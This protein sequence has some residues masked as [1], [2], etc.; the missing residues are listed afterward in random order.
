MQSLPV[1]VEDQQET[2]EQRRKRLAIEFRMVAEQY[3]AKLTELLNEGV[4][5]EVNLVG[6]YTLT[7]EDALVGHSDISY[8]TP[9]KRY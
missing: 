3:N 2:K 7:D 5:V 9:P 6:G 4:K 8:Q 1:L